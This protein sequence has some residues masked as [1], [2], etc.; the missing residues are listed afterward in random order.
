MSPPHPLPTPPPPPAAAKFLIY[1]ASKLISHSVVSSSLR[2]HGLY[3]THQVPLSMGLPRQEYWSGLPF[4]SP[5]RGS[6]WPRSWICISCWA[7]GFF[8]TEPAGK[9]HILFRLVLNW[10]CSPWAHTEGSQWGERRA[11]CPTW[12]LR[13]GSRCAEGTQK[14]IPS[15]RALQTM[16][17]HL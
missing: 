9:P 10:T 7:G 3:V 8:T 1:W 2:L 13:M 6:F 11:T 12:G 16:P 15:L 5:G 17:E 4:P 14:G